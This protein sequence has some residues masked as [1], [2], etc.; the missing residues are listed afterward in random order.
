VIRKS[1]ISRRIFLCLTGGL[2]MRLLRAE[3]EAAAPLTDTAKTVPGDRFQA[4]LTSQLSGSARIPIAAERIV[5]VLGKDE[6]GHPLEISIDLTRPASDPLSLRVNAIREPLQN[7]ET[8]THWPRLHVTRVPAVNVARLRVLFE[9]MGPI[10]SGN[11]K[12]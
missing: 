3:T 11:S 10:N 12:G 7:T 8:W 4:Y 9:E 1:S 5:V 2:Q 6:R